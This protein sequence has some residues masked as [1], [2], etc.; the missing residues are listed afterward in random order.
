MRIL[1]VQES[2]YLERGPHQGHHLLER[3]VLRGHDVHVIDYPINW[4]APGDDGAISPRIINLKV[5]KAVAPG[6]TVIRP[7]II[8]L[9]ALNYISL[10]VTHRLE[11]ARQIKE[12]RPDIIVGFGL[13]NASIAIQLARRHRIPFIYYVIDE[14]H[15]LVPELVFQPFAKA[16]EMSN[17]RLADRVISINQGLK[18]YTEEMG[19]APS[20][21]Q[22]IR[23]G[24]DFDKFALA[25]GTAV[26]RRFGFTEQDTVLFFM[27]WLYDFCGLDEVAMALAH[28][29]NKHLK[30]MVL[31]KGELWNRLNEIKAQEGLG[32]RLILEGWKPYSEVP[33][34]L[35]AADICLLPAKRSKTMENIVPIKMYEY[36]AA[37]KTVFATSLSGICKEFSNGNGVMYM[38]SP[39][40]VVPMA[41][42][43]RGDGAMAAEGK[44][45]QAFVRPNDWSLMTDEFERLLRE[46]C[47]G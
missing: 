23:A 10:L 37:G 24:V 30:M 14:L 33:N 38:N 42:K 29:E 47:H 19:A 21:T 20:K 34:Y 46:A 27:G 43:I 18:E 44:N 41:E 39:T 40:E 32:D 22:I 8:R 5:F 28:S 25:D 1:V 17:N 15:R 4:R 2:G 12:F 11:I 45:G 35:A 13:L 6:V 26:R 9:P 7:A 36:L 3:M 31:G 16:V